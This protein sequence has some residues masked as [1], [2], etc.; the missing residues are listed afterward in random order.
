MKRPICQQC[1]FPVKTCLCS[2]VSPLNSEFNIYIL[3]HPLE[4]RVSKNTAR[5]IQL[6]H[7][8]THI[9]V[10][11]NADD[12][13]EVKTRLDNSI[14]DICLVYPDKNSVVIKAPPNNLHTSLSGNA[15]SI[16]EGNLKRLQVQRAPRVLLFIDATWRKAKKMYELNPWLKRFKAIR[17]EG[18]KPSYTIRKVPDDQSYSTIEAVIYAIR[19]FSNESTKPLVDL[20]FKM[21]EMQMKHMSSEVKERY[22]KR[23]LSS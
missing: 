19:A 1:L 18:G 13:N 20:F 9:F 11:E 7:H 10:G 12:F 15:S 3:Q 14:A 5:L 16:V 22:S 6:C 21:Q 2:Y 23:S 17:I 4:S 8:R